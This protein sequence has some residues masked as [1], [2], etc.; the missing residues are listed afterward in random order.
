MDGRAQNDRGGAVPIDAGVLVEALVLGGDERVLHD[1]R[2]LVDLDQ[3]AALETELGDESSINRVE[4]RRLV[5]RVLAENFDRRALA[6]AADESPGS[7]EEA[8]AQGDEECERKQHHSD[9]RR[10]PPVEWNLVVRGCS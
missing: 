2:N 10:V 6:A 9:E 4:L 1:L 7:V 5:R 3:R 8:R